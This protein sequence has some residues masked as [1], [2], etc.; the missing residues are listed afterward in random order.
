MT[1]LQPG[2]PEAPAVKLLTTT[3]VAPPVTLLQ[4]SKAPEAPPVKLIPKS[5]TPPPALPVVKLITPPSTP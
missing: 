4:G 1:L 3:P 2:K 5:T